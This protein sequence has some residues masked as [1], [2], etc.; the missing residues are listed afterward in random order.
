[1]CNDTVIKRG[2][3]LYS[4]LVTPAHLFRAHDIY[5]VILTFIVLNIL[6][7]LLTKL[8]GWVVKCTVIYI[9]LSSEMCF[10]PTITII[11]QYNGTKVL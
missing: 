1:M 8:L 9:T 2:Y 4:I 11:D 5:S 6:I 10:V 7:V 3:L